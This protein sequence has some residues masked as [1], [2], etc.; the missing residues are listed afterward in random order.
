MTDEYAELRSTAEKASSATKGPWRSNYNNGWY[1]NRAVADSY[2]AAASPQVIL[3]LLVKLDVMTEELVA[4]GEA[5]RHLKARIEE[6]EKEQA[7][8]LNVA[9]LVAERKY[10]THLAAA[11]K[12][13]EAVEK[14][15][16]LANGPREV[17]EAV[18]AYRALVTPPPCIGND[19][20]CPCHDGLWCNYVDDP[21]TGTKGFKIP[22]VAPEK[23]A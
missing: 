23:K 18:G 15:Q 9:V 4:R 22:A 14:Y 3:G 11:E 21:K 1:V 7:E 16:I 20:T 10:G 17:R 6:L 8:F 12:C 2:I 13:V 5:I 19:P